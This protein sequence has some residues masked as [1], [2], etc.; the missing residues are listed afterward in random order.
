MDSGEYLEV[1]QLNA[2]INKA[3]RE[4]RCSS[5]LPTHW[6]HLL[7]VVLCHGKKKLS[8]IKRVCRKN[9][10]KC[11]VK[12]INNNDNKGLMHF[13]LPP[14]PRLHQCPTFLCVSDLVSVQSFL[15]FV[16]PSPFFPNSYFKDPQPF[17]EHQRPLL[18]RFSTSTM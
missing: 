11:N 9:N 1:F 10:D 13:G 8:H 5:D 18:G 7:N 3:E 16:D 6:L 17:S 12:K 4:S 15:H 14:S 2:S